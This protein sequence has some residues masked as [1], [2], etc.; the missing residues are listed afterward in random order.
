MKVASKQSS[1]LQIIIATSAFGLGVNF[2]S[3]SVFHSFTD[4]FISV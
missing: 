3:I 4:N 1:N 2:S